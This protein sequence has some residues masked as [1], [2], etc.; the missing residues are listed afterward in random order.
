VTLLTRTGVSIGW[1]IAECLAASAVMAG[2]LMGVRHGARWPT[3]AA[4]HERA[5]SQRGVSRPAPRRSQARGGD[6]VTLWDAIERGED[7]TSDA[8]G[9]R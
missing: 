1:A 8:S 9:P 3:L 2:G 7:P 5:Q 4:R 6:A